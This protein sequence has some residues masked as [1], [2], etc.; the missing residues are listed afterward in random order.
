MR[1]PLLDLSAQYKTIRTEIKKAVDEVFESQQFVLGPWVSQL[2]SQIAAYSEVQHAIG[3][4]SGSD[5]LLLALMALDIRP[6]DE[7]IT[8]PYTFFATAG[9]IAR[10]QARTVFVDIDPKTYNID[11]D[12]IEKKITSRTKA[13]IPVHL[14]GQCAEMDPILAIAER[15]HLPVIE[16]AAQSIG[17]TYKGR[18]AG[19]MGAMGCLSFF[20]SKNL[21]GAGDGGMILTQDAKLAEKIRILRV[22]G[23]K[24]KYVHQVL[25][26]NS[27]LDSIQ[28]ATLSVKLPYL[29]EWSRKREENALFYNKQLG[30]LN[31][32]VVPYIESYNKSVYN[33][34][35][36]RVPNRDKLLDYL[37]EKEIGCE[38]YYPIPPSSA[39]LLPGPRL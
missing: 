25:G 3:V 39:G 12:Q 17:A 23:S 19:S 10:L 9:S 20:P 27:R 34:Y 26:C 5:A 32:I 11:P 7:V 35:V 28:A 8:T 4:A 16:D 24:P 1:V 21:G 2:E 31:Q 6:G 36:I 13:I 18:K 15:H 33:Q 37:K 30:H 38:V 22:H 14:Y 29:D